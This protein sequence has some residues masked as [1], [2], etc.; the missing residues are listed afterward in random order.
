MILV[1]L[2]CSHMHAVCACVCVCMCVML[3]GKIF[4]HVNKLQLFDSILCRK[5]NFYDL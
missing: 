2:I 4:I 1:D 3:I 5:P